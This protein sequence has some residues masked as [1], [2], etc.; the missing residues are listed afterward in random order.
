MVHRETKAQ[1][2]KRPKGEG[3]RGGTAHRREHA[4]EKEPQIFSRF[5]RL[6]LRQRHQVVE[7]LRNH[8]RGG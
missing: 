1:R 8:F 3:Q 7:R 6:A 4:A 5:D 2:E